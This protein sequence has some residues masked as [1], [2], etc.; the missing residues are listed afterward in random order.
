MDSQ[1]PTSRALVVDDE[2]AILIFAERTLRDAGYEVVL[3]SDGPEALR[4]VAVQPRFDVF[5]VDVLMPRMSGDE[6]ARRLRQMDPDVKVLCC[7]GYSDRLFKGKL[8]LWEHEA[9]VD[10]PVSGT[11]LREAVSLLLFGHTDGP[12]TEP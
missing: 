7:T 1:Q 11:G 8:A 2:A 9:S 10:K 4:L 6:L 5:V 3:A 12:E